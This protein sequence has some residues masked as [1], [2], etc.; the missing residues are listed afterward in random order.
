MARDASAA[1][2]NEAISEYCAGKHD[3]VPSAEPVVQRMVRGD[4]YKLNYYHGLAPQLF[5][6]QEDPD[7]LHDLASDLE[8]RDILDR[9]MARLMDDWN[10]EQVRA[11]I[12]SREIDNAIMKAW[13]RK[14]RPRETHRWDMPPGKHPSLLER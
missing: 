2:K 13:A 12:V 11:A 9:L 3:P 6:L 5:D 1:W 8:H 10:P 7:E 14:T 4:R